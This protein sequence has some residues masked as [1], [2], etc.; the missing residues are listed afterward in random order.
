VLHFLKFGL[1]FYFGL[2]QQRES[3]RER[4]QSQVLLGRS[5]IARPY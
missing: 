3:G 1:K 5:E 2:N 4:F